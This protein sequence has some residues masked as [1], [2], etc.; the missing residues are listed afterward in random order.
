M[1]MDSLRQFVKTLSNDIFM[2]NAS[3]ELKTFL[4]KLLHLR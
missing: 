1:Y 2:K 3:C 4:E